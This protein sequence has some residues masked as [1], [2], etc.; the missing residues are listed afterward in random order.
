[1]YI[2]YKL[3]DEEHIVL[4]LLLLNSFTELCP[5]DISLSQILREKEQTVL[6]TLVWEL[7]VDDPE[8]DKE[9][10]LF[11]GTQCTEHS[12]SRKSVVLALKMGY[13]IKE[14]GHLVTSPEADDDI[15]AAASWIGPNFLYLLVNVVLYRWKSRSNQDKHQTIKC[16]RAMLRFLPPEDSLKFMPQ[17]MVAVSNAMGSNEA[18]ERESIHANTL[19]FLAV[20]TLFDFVKVLAAHSMWNVED[21]LTSIVVILFPLFGKNVGHYNVARSE[22]VSLLLWLA[23][24]SSSSFN[25]IPF[26]PVTPDLQPVRDLLSKK[27]IIID[28]IRLISQQAEHDESAVNHQLQSKFY[29]QMNIL[30]D[31]IA[32]HENK[33]VR[34]V[35][36]EHM[37][38]LIRANRDL[39]TNMIEN[40]TLASMHF[41]TVVHEETGKIGK[42]LFVT[43]AIFHVAPI[44]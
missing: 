27:N 38:K 23:E 33:E 40:E 7:G 14:G 3:Q 10:E 44:Y 26:L 13:L 2:L 30:S 9:N 11:N 37:T 8:E 34:K 29:A 21:N 35:V 41:L 5:P 43:H 16:L 39:F 31:L 25:E 6:K 12:Y 17:V 24:K 15:S 22:A 19:R 18:S 42:A 4:Q 28:D 32:K 36:I 20:S 1:M